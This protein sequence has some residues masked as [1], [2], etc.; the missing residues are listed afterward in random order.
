MDQNDPI[1]NKD[2]VNKVKKFENI[3]NVLFISAFLN[4]EQ[5][6]YPYLKLAQSLKISSSV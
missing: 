2:K 1:L 6:H 4:Q 3:E 5:S